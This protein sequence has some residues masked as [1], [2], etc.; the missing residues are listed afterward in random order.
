L[1]DG[2]GIDGIGK[3]GPPAPPKPAAGSERARGGEA[4]RPFEV[5]PSKTAAAAVAPAAPAGTSPLERLRAGEIDLDGYLDLK[6]SEATAHLKGLRA[7]EMEGLRA[8][9]R[10]QLTGDPSMLDLVEQ[11]T[12][13]RPISK[14]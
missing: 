13:Q 12:G 1:E 14:E 2:M 6:V 9:L 7:H 11:A 4:S 10:E 8:L 3:G 5:S